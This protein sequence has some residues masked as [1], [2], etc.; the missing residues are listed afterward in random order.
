MRNQ[1]SRYHVLMIAPTSFF[2]DYGCHIRILEE[3][4]VLRRLGHKVTIV[5]Y[6]KGRAIADLDIVRTPPL[7]WRA[8]YEVGSS[9]HKIAFDTYLSFTVLSTA[10]RLK[11]DI[12]HGHI[13]EGALIGAPVARLLGLPLV[14]DFQGS[15]TGEMVDHHFLNPEGPFF[16][17][18]RGLEWLINRLPQVILTSSTHARSMLENE[19]GVP[20]QRIQPLPDC[21]NADV[22]CPPGANSE[23]ARLALKQELG[24]PPERPVVI[25]LGLLAEYQGTSHLIKAA[26]GLYKKGVDAHFLIMGYPNQE[27]YARMAQDLGVGDRVTLTGKIPYE[28]APT[29]LSVGDVA[30]APKLSA[31]EGS[32]KV[33]NYMAMELP[34]VA[35]DTAVHREYL[36]DLGVYAPPGDTESLAG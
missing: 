33:L 25:Y 1:D 7:P 9:R 19:F 3:A 36:G 11:P 6:Y 2:A 27:S 30:V 10:L 20:A 21:V 12:I 24:I 5:T 26:A 17:P 35:F 4:L 32:G 18:A 14:F 29:Y 22:F 16:R 15:M 13:H 31:T 8:D 34:T 23:S 28:H